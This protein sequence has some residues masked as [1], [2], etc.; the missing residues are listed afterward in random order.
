MVGLSFTPLAEC[1]IQVLWFEPIK[2][3]RNKAKKITL[4]K[5]QSSLGFSSDGS[6]K[7]FLRCMHD[8]TFVALVHIV[9]EKKTE[10]NAITQQNWLVNEP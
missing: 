10:L 9:F 6:F 4:Q 1:M 3:L 5:M 8:P 7:T 2:I